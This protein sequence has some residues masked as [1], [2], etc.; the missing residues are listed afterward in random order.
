MKKVYYSNDFKGRWP[1]G[2]A[3]LVVANDEAEARTLLQAELDKKGLPQSEFTL[4][5]VSRAEVGVTI[6][7]DGDY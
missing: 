4:K 5:R 7:A 2:T 3:A 6:L 1:V